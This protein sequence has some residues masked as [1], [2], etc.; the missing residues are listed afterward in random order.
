MNLR[1]DKHWSYGARTR[2]GDAIGPRAFVVNAPVQTDKTKESLLEIQKELAD[3]LGSRPATQTELDQAK[4][5]ETLT[6]A[7]RW[8]TNSAVLASLAQLV[9]YELPD[10]Y[11]TTY[12]GQVRALTTAD[13]D[14]AAKTIIDPRRAVWIVVGD[15]AKIEPGVREAGIGEVVVIDADGKPVGPKP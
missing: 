1:E 10:D 8:E 13:V 7:G 6:L 15:R 11:W 5:E 2:L 12:A 9:R 4:A 3:I 14:A